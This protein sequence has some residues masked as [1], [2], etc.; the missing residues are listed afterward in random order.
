MPTIRHSRVVP[1]RLRPA[2]ENTNYAFGLL[3]DIVF[4]AKL[5][6]AGQKELRD[7]LIDLQERLP[8]RQRFQRRGIGYP[9]QRF[10][11]WPSLAASCPYRRLTDR[12]Q[13]SMLPADVS[14]R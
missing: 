6:E 7:S 2:D 11:N 4:E 9:P 3:P 14:C 13:G 12:W 5:L 8:L 1:F 10:V